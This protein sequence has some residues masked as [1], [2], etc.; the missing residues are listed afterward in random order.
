MKKIIAQQK[1][2]NKL[3]KKILSEVRDRPSRF[4]AVWVKD[5]EHRKH[6]DRVYRLLGYNTP[7]HQPIQIHRPGKI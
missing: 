2:T 4:T 5:D 7:S 6:I 1:L 3:L